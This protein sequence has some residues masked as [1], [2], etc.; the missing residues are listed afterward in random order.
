MWDKNRFREFTLDNGLEVALYETDEPIF[1]GKLIVNNAGFSSEKKDEKGVAHFLEHMLFSV[2]P[3]S[4]RQDD[5]SR[6]RKDAKFMT[7]ATHFCKVLYCGSGFSHDVINYLKFLSASLSHPSFDTDEVEKEKHVI[8][9]EISD[10]RYEQEGLKISFMRKLFP[11][12]HPYMGFNIGSEHD[13]SKI[14]PDVLRKFHHRTYFSDNMELI[15][16]G[17]LPPNIEEIVKDLF[18]DL[19]RGEKKQ[20]QDIHIPLL[21]ES[22]LYHFPSP[23]F[24]NDVLPEQSNALVMIGFNVTPK[25]L[26]QSMVY[27]L[28]KYLF[29][30]YDFNLPVFKEFRRKYGMAYSIGCEH[31]LVNPSTNFDAHI[32]I[33]SH[34]HAERLKQGISWFLELIGDLQDNLLDEYTLDRLKQVNKYMSHVGFTRSK[35]PMNDGVLN[36]TYMTKILGKDI[37]DGGL[38][39]DTITSEDVMEEMRKYAPR[40]F[41]KDPCLI[42]VYDPLKSP[43]AMPTREEVRKFS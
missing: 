7:G 22:A 14:N 30:D 39:M 13:I 33:T 41:Q 16:T 4:L 10:K 27:S 32:I 20:R 35:D 2:T 15:L 12:N 25:T 26:K 9:R 43:I 42:H 21:T 8:L 24:K 36:Y 23:G 37:L 28:V 38:I 29:S 3:N 34:V 5:Y 11:E 19:P 31:T 1:A 17:G 40:N 18:G 6:I